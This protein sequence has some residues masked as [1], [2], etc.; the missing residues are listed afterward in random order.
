M[1]LCQLKWYLLKC[2]VRKF[3][4]KYTKHVAKEK[5]QQRPN[6]E[7]LLKKFEGKM[8]EDNLSKS[9]SVKNILDEIYDHIAEGT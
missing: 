1:S 6:L 7:N 2:E 9:T 5:R 4:I 8:D 3:T